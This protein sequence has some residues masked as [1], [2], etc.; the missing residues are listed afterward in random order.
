MY[1][2]CIK[3]LYAKNKCINLCKKVLILSYFISTFLRKRECPNFNQ[4]NGY[5][6]DINEGYCIDC[7]D[8]QQTVDLDGNIKDEK[9]YN[10][11]F[12]DLLWHSD[13]NLTDVER[14]VNN[15]YMLEYIS[16]NVDMSPLPIDNNLYKKNEETYDEYIYRNY[17]CMNSSYNNSRYEYY[18]KKC[19][20]NDCNIYF[21][22][23]NNEYLCKDCNVK[24]IRY[25]IVFNGLLEKVCNGKKVIYESI[26]R[27]LYNKIYELY[28]NNKIGFYKHRINNKYIIYSKKKNK[29]INLKYKRKLNLVKI[30]F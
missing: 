25:K 6:D 2:K 16:N 12:S 8:D 1:N 10:K 20:T 28:I 27:N 9:I 4:C 19:I 23:R 17:G 21:W 15:D 24:N 5:I 3:C 30:E 29:I 26:N 22:G 18:R 7:I 14:K 11:Y 13:L